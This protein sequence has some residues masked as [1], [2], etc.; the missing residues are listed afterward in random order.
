MTAETLFRFSEI[1]S[2]RVRV[3]EMNGKQI[4]KT[5]RC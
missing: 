3:L 5:L 4:G 1:L 2:E